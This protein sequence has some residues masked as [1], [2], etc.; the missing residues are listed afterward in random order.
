[1]ARVYNF[2]AVAVLPSAAPGG[3]RMLDYD[4]AT[5][6]VDDHRSQALREHHRDGRGRPALTSAEFP[7][8][9]RCSCRRRFT[10]QFAGVPMNL[11]QNKKADYIVSAPWSKRGLERDEALRRARCVASSG[12]ENFSYGARRGGLEGFDPGADW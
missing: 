8:T 11:M 5:S 2:S 10:Q 1:M 3:R 7:T 6:V 9:A 12:D 4:G